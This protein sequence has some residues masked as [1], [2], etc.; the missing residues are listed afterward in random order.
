MFLEPQ[1]CH[2]FDRGGNLVELEVGC[3]KVQTLIK[4][5]GHL[6]TIEPVKSSLIIYIIECELGGGFFLSDERA[7]TRCT[8]MAEAQRERIP[9]REILRLRSPGG[10]S[11]RFPQRAVTLT[12]IVHHW[13]CETVESW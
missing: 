3:L 8:Q 7:G 13:P 11:R 1:S 4:E 10:S 12:T 6:K 9:F 5:K 2:S